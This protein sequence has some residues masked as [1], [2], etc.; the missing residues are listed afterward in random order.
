MTYKN[1]QNALLSTDAS[2]RCAEQLAKTS[3]NAFS[4]SD[5]ASSGGSKRDLHS[6]RIEEH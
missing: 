3:A 1:V 5:V 2:T 6:L 4:K